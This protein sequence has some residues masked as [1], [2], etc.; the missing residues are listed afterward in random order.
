[1]IRADIL[2]VAALDASLDGLPGIPIEAKTCG[3]TK[4]LHSPTLS[5][6]AVRGQSATGESRWCPRQFP[7]DAHHATGVP[8]RS[9]SG[10]PSR[11]EFAAPRLRH[12]RPDG[13]QTALRP[14]SPYCPAFL[15]APTRWLGAPPAALP[16]GR[17]TY[18]L[19]WPGSAENVR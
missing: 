8:R 11:R 7:P 15:A 3:N 17:C 18:R 16:P 5:C 6:P 13:S 1:M 9:R 4:R 14:P 2:Y 19:A 12:V 10:S